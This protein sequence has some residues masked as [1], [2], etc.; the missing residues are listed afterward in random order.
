MIMHTS[1]TVNM[2]TATKIV[3]SAINIFKTIDIYDFH[4]YIW[5]EHTIL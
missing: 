2:I 3:M 5:L 4:D 1:H